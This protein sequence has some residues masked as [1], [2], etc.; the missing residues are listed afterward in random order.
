MPK[1]NLPIWD[2]IT[3]KARTRDL[4][5]QRIQK[6]LIKGI[7]AFARNLVSPSQ[8]QKDTLALLINCNNEMNNARKEFLKEDINPKYRHLCKP[9]APVT[10]ELFGDN[11]GKA[12]KDIAEEQKAVAG[13]ANYSV[14]NYN[15][16]PKQKKYS[17]SSRTH[18]YNR[19]GG[20]GVRHHG[21]GPYNPGM[22]SFLD[23]LSQVQTFLNQGSNQKFFNQKRGSTRRQYN[24]SEKPHTATQPPAQQ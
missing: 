10:K 18:P 3:S 19:H 15:K 4:R 21:R 16:T 17:Y 1:V 14:S 23:Q 9:S 13:V 8:E 20:S 11:L 22:K 6:P 24:R 7:T 5:M 2:S 12:C